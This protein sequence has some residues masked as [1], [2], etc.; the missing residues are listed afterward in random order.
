MICLRLP[1]ETDPAAFLR[2]L[3]TLEWNGRFI[4]SPPVMFFGC[5]TGSAI[6]GKAVYSYET[7]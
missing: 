1:W 4:S 6:S 2:C 3:T 5:Y 7:K